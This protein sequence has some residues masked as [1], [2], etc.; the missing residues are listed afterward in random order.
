MS[1][2]IQ[3]TYSIRTSSPVTKTFSFEP[4]SVVKFC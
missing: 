4:E 3:D 1:M 2:M